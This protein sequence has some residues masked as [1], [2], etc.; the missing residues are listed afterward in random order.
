M[1]EEQEEV[2]TSSGSGMEDFYEIGSHT[3]SLMD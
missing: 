3:V 2:V 1:V